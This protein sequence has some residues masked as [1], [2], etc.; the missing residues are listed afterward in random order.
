[1]EFRN[2]TETGVLARSRRG[3]SQAAAVLH[4]H[5]ETCLATRWLRL[6]SFCGERRRSREGGWLH[7][8]TLKRNPWFILGLIDGNAT[9]DASSRPP[10]KFG[11]RTR[12]HQTVLSARL[13][14]K[15]RASQAHGHAAA[16][17]TVGLT[18]RC[19]LEEAEPR[20]KRR[21][22][23]AQPR[24]LVANDGRPAQVIRAART[25]APQ[26]WTNHA[27]ETRCMYPRRQAGKSRQD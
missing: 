7:P 26:T 10:H 15:P 17:E 20:E 23:Q 1:M 16:T 11:G 3:I 21:P 5:V 22:Q 9:A 24:R 25:R 13:S 18:A 14:K 4:L 8:S 27:A 19:R 6:T 12:T 2:S